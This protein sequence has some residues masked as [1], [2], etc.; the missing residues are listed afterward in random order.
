MSPVVDKPLKPFKFAPAAAKSAVGTFFARNSWSSTPTNTQAASVPDRNAHGATVMPLTAARVGGAATATATKTAIAAIVLALPQT[1]HARFSLTILPPVCHPPRAIKR[2]RCPPSGAGVVGN[3]ARRFGATWSATR[4]ATNPARVHGPWVKRIP[5]RT[6]GPLRQRALRG[7]PGLW[8]P[9]RHR[10]LANVW[11]LTPR[12][13]RCHGGI[14]GIHF[15]GPF[16]MRARGHGRRRRSRNLE[17]PQAS[18]AARKDD[19]A[20]SPRMPPEWRSN[21]NWPDQS[22]EKEAVAE[23]AGRW[24]RHEVTY[25]EGARFDRYASA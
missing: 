3:E 5:P 16:T 11:G 20:L 15:A 13:E 9:M 24:G 12:R 18:G 8:H 21:Y 19:R 14:R 6:S 23:G 25:D 22:A 17:A 4:L 2:V 1:R 10:Y 7:L